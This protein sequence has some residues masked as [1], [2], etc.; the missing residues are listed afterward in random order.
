MPNVPRI[1]SLGVHVNSVPSACLQKLI[2]KADFASYIHANMICA[3]SMLRALRLRPPSLPARFSLF[4]GLV[5]IGISPV[6]PTQNSYPSSITLAPQAKPMTVADVIKLSKAGLSDDIV[7]Q[8][9]RK[10]GQHFD[11]ST[12]QLIQL[13]DAHVS[14]RVIQVML[15]PTSG[16]V[17]PSA[18]KASAPAAAVQAAQLPQ[19]ASR[20]DG[21]QDSALPNEIGVYAKEKGNW[22]EILPEV[23]N[24]KTGGV[25]KSVATVGVVKGDVNGHVN[26]ESSRNRLTTPMELLIVVPDGTAITEYQLLRLHQ[27]SSGREFR[28]VTGGVFHVSGGATR[29]LLPFDGTKVSG[30][31][32]KVALSGLSAGEYGFLPPGAFRSSNEASSGK[33]Y[34]FKVIE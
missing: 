24:W 11:L 33:I 2:D 27:H 28:T 19:Q 25:M 3:I 30:R 29:D 4:L 16:A 7:I 20:Q 1:F 9:I 18:Q 5:L 10:K 32:Y 14:E 21:P 22:V 15:D 12:D 23:V 34:S 31:T 6:A 8:Q 26:G 13:K 17:P